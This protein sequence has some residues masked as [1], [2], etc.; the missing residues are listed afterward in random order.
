[1]YRRI[2]IKYLRGG[3]KMEVKVCMR[4]KKMFQYITGPSICPKCRQI[5]EEQFQKVK[6]YL[7]ENPG[8]AMNVV[9]EETSVPVKLIQSFLKQGRLEVV[10]GSPMM[11]QCEKCGAPIVTGKYCNKCKAEL[12]G[13]LSAVASEITRAKDANSEHHNEKMRFL[14]SDRI[15]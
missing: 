11:I 3:I 8:A 15:R 2:E 9:S 10:P 4:C 12:V 7:R 13:E 6:E 14:K 5:E 1:M